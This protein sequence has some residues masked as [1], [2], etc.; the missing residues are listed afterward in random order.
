MQF[1]SKTFCPHIIDKSTPMKTYL[2]CTKIKDLCKMINYSPNGTMTPKQDVQNVGCPFGHTIQDIGRTK[3]EK[4]DNVLNDV[5][6]E[7]KTKAQVKT[8][9]QD[10]Q[11][12]EN[13]NYTKNT[14]NKG[15]GKSKKTKKSYRKEGM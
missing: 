11:K 14:I 9:A 2:Y 7:I 10:S 3:Q 13:N 4:S 8:K 1:N 6:K 12:K 5:P 15:K